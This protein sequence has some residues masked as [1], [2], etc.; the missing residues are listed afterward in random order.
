MGHVWI[1]G[2]MCGHDSCA[3]SHVAACLLQAPAWL[4]PSREATE[5]NP[6]DILEAFLQGPSGTHPSAQM[7]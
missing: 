6:G 1:Q 4:Q 2:F 5:M 7:D 3:F